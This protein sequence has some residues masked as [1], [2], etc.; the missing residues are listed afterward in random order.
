MVLAYFFHS[1]G[2]LIILTIGKFLW[3][4]VNVS[5]ESD[6]QYKIG[7][8]SFLKKNSDFSHSAAIDPVVFVQ[9]FDVQIF[10]FSR[11]YRLNRF[12]KLKPKFFG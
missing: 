10:Q 1:L 12:Y 4:F 8:S 7:F 2:I 6:V 9:F 3:V 5:A 11:G